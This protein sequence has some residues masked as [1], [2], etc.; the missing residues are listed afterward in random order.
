[1]RAHLLQKLGRLGAVGALSFGLRE[2]ACENGDQQRE[3]RCKEDERV[4]SIRPV[5]IGMDVDV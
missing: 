5:L 3:N 4:M 1:M 2:G